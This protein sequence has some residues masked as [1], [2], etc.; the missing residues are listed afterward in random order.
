[1]AVRVAGC[2]GPAEG[3]L[4]PPAFILQP[5]R[6]LSQPI[7]SCISLCADSRQNRPNFVYSLSVGYFL[8]HSGKVGIRGRQV[9]LQA[10]FVFLDRFAVQPFEAALG[11]G[12]SA[13]CYEPVENS[14]HIRFF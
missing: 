13:L 3:R 6:R 5:N 12:Q 1:M 7:W 9:G 10:A 11:I 14:D 8:H 4:Q 2:R